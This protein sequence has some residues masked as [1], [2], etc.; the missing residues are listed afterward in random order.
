MQ[1]CQFFRGTA[2]DDHVNF[3]FIQHALCPFPKVLVLCLYQLPLVQLV[4]GTHP[5]SQG[6]VVGDRH[7]S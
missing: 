5:A 6:L 1:L 3:G 2:S 7:Q 4:L